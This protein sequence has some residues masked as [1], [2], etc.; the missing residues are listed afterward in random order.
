MKIGV[1]LRGLLAAPATGV[2]QYA[3]N[4]L[5]ELLQTEPDNE[6]VFFSSSA[7]P[8][9]L[10]PEFLNQPRIR[11][12]HLKLPNKLFNFSLKFFNGPQLD[13]LT[14]GPDVFWFPNLNFWSLSQSCPAIITVHDLSFEKIPWAYSLKRRL[15][16]QAVKPQKKLCRA[17][18][19]ITVSHNTK[20]DLI[21]EYHLEPDKIEVIYPVLSE[22]SKKTVLTGSFINS[23]PDKFL[24][25]L[26]TLEPRKNIEGIIRA[27][28]NADL[29]QYSLV[30][31]G[32]R[33]WLYKR[34]YNLTRELNLEQRVKFLNYV[35]KAEKSVLLKRAALL[36]WPSF[37]E[38][39]G[40][41][42]LEAM[43]AGCPVVS[44]ANSSLPEVL[45]QAALLVDPYNIGEI[46]RAIEQAVKDV[47]L[48]EI[49]IAKGLKQVKKYNSQ[50]SAKK[51]LKIFYD[52]SQ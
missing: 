10:P 8:L 16:H 17:K 11:H 3:F 44:S 25:F 41:P 27:F 31:A 26:G 19:L 42:P 6:Y 30:I 46:S 32:G 52:L 1:D 48:R 50:E 40:F 23:L 2:G 51:M 37:Y 5:K 20:N 49:L 9:L 24:L 47:R 29:P 15:W 35:T 43:S 39:F 12:C 13:R 14:G 34:I 7:K 38:G 21:K 4:L 45:G 33:G 22:L 18:K 28:A 36:I